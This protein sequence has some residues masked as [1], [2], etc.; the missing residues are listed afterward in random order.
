M[1]SP[2]FISVRSGHPLFKQVVIAALFYADIAFSGAAVD[3]AAP[4]IPDSGGVAWMQGISLIESGE[5][6]KGVRLLDSMRTSGICGEAFLRGY[7]E[8]VFHSLV[9]KKAG[10]EM[11]WITDR[12]IVITDT[13]SPASYRWDVVRSG[14]P[15][16]NDRLPCFTY[17]ATFEIRKP[18]HVVFTGLTQSKLSIMQIGYVSHPAPFNSIVRQLDNRK[19]QASCRLFID[20]NATGSPTLEYLSKRIRGVYDSIAIKPELQ[21]YRGLSLRCYTVSRFADEDGKFT[22]IAS[23]DRTLPDLKSRIGP[24]SAKSPPPTVRYTLV[25]ESSSDV[26]DLLEAKFQS[27]LRAF[28]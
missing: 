20:L 15:P 13:I 17:G 22:A 23:F 24:F 2:S 16:R 21:S 11:A 8:C 10:V 5:I 28:L 27:L 1:A 25:V 4:A 6:T 9:P 12:A 14:N 26:K 19:N 18:F 7:A 3:T